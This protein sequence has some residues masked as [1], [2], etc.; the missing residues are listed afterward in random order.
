M[1]LLVM[2]TS[3]AGK[4]Q[5]MAVLDHARRQS[6]I[7]P[8]YSGVVVKDAASSPSREGRTPTAPCCVCGIAFGRPPDVPE[9]WNMK[10]MSFSGAS[11]G[12]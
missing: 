6:A 10:A 9:V 5:I 8:W 1:F 4:S 12:A 3:V 11:L 2:G 7:P